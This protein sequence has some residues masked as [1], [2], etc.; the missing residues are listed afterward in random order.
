MRGKLVVR[1]KP[2]AHVFVDG[3]AAGA[4][5]ISREL[6][7]GKHRVRLVNEDLGKSDS[8]VV[9]IAAGRELLVERSW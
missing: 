5:P 8:I 6:S 2:W 9:T 7:P 4:T 1:V 3:R